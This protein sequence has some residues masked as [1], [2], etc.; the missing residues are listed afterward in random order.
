MWPAVLA[1]ILVAGA[2]WTQVVLVATWCMEGANTWILQIVG[3]VMGI[4][5]ETFSRILDWDDRSTA[6]LFGDGAGA[7]RYMETKRAR[8]KV[9]LAVD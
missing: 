1:I 3:R 8:G 5:G 2:V 7:H 4:G 6:V 9:V